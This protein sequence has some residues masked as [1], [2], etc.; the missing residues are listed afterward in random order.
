MFAKLIDR[1]LIASWERVGR[2]QQTRV[3]DAAPPLST[4]ARNLNDG[5]TTSRV[6]QFTVHD[7]LNGKY[8]EYAR[9]RWNPNGPDEYVRE[10][11]IVQPDESLVDAISAVL[12]ILEK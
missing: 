7:A 9:R 4:T 12:V 10:V 6:Q 3:D 1:I 8:I 11:Y 2:R 5:P